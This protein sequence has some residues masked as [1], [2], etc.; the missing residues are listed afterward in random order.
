VQVIA[1]Q[2]VDEGSSHDV[3][4]MLTDEDPLPSGGGYRPVEIPLFVVKGN[5]SH[6]QKQPQN[7]ERT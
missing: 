2:S 1:F 5:Q 6:S 3:T 7:C 4:P